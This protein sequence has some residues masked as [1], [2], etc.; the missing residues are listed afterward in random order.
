MTLR[1]S[2]R[3]FVARVAALSAAAAGVAVL[4]RPDSA[5]ALVE[6]GGDCDM[7][8]GR[9]TRPYKGFASIEDT[10]G[11]QCTTHAALRFDS[12]APYPGVNWRGNARSWY[13]N[14]AA[15][16]WV[17]TNNIK[18]VRPGMIVVWGDSPAHTSPAG[19]GHVAYVESVWPEGITVSEM[20]WGFGCAG[21]IR[22]RARTSM[23]GIVSH[24]PLTWE[25][26][27][28]RGQYRLAG[29]VVPERR[30]PVPVER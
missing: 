23:W 20:N 10:D 17:V 26:A 24:T 2:R 21:Q 8:W 9:E 14:A 1:H 12:G 4:G 22:E 19:N 6:Y 25:Q 11:G 13:L 3:A 30:R 15:A 28:Q 27:K 5:E 18:A 29:F 16:G 7:T